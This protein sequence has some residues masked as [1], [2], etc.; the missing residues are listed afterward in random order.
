MLPLNRCGDAAEGGLRPSFRQKNVRPRAIEALPDDRIDGGKNRDQR[1]IGV[2]NQADYAGI[3]DFGRSPPAPC[4]H[5][6]ATGKRL[7]HR[8]SR[9]LIASP[10]GSS[11]VQRAH[12][13]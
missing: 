7:A 11:R 1:G 2:A 8:E 13:G 5:R 9:G 10:E 4:D 12:T 3:D 6:G